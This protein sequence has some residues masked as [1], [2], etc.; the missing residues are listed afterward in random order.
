MVRRPLRS[1]LA[2]VGAALAVG[3][4]SVSS[5]QAATSDGATAASVS[6]QSDVPAAT[7]PVSPVG[8]PASAVSV[9][10]RIDPP[11]LFDCSRAILD[12]EGDSMEAFISSTFPEAMWPALVHDAI[13]A[14]PDVHGDITLVNNAI[15]G[16]SLVTS[17]FAIPALTE[18]LPRHLAGYSPEQLQR[19]I[20]AIDP[21]AIQLFQ[22]GTDEH[23]VGTSVDALVGLVR[24]VKSL[25]VPEVLVLPTMPTTEERDRLVTDAP[26]NRRAAMQN[27]R[28]ASL[29]LLEPTLVRSPLLVDGTDLGDPRYF[30]DFV[31]PEA[32]PLRG[33]R[34]DGT[35]PD[36]EGHA[37]LAEAI[38]RSGFFERAIP[39]V[40]ERQET[41]A[42]EPSP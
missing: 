5:R 14:R 38:M 21:N 3:C 29:G 28:L 35:H 42:S 26:L 6:A 20:V 13:D 2:C 41:Q 37:R 1:V 31:H 16:S 30:D 11:P 32:S 4:T 17:V 25:G 39:A 10:V 27:A 18:N 24:Y 15:P 8:S 9:A 12:V 19:M 40:C 23:V 33:L 22:H 7:L 36:R 34:G